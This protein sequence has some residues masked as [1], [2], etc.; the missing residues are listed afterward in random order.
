RLRFHSSS[1]VFVLHFIEILLLLSARRGQAAQ[2]V[3]VFVAAPQRVQQDGQLAGGG[4]DG[5]ALAAARAAAGGQTQA[6]AAQRAVLAEGA[7]DVLGALHQQPAQ[8][9]VA[10]A[11][12]AQLGG[13]FARV[14]ALR[15]QSDE[16]PGRA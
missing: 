7:E 4:D 2:R 12:D 5:A 9:A 8:Q 3:E 1:V 6:P 15:P 14:A 10:V 13:G 16:G 11:G